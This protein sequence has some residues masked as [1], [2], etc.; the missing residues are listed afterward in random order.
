MVISSLQYALTNSAVSDAAS[1]RVCHHLVLRAF[2]AYAV[3]VQRM[4]TVVDN[5][6][7]QSCSSRNIWQHLAFKVVSIVIWSLNILNKT[8]F[9]LEYRINILYLITN[10]NIYSYCFSIEIFGNGNV[11]IFVLKKYV[12]LVLRFGISI[13][14]RS[15]K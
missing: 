10:N 5:T 7:R 4:T 14:K 12:I 9:S 2:Y 1:F 8:S 15:P 11:M 3:T 13:D 6:D